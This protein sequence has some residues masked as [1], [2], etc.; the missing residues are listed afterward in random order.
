MRQIELP[1]SSQD[2]HV[3]AA[4][5]AQHRAMHN[6]KRNP[7][8][9]PLYALQ[10]QAMSIGIITQTQQEKPEGKVARPLHAKLFAQCKQ[11]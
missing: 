7:P 9:L 2:V 8:L 11:T 10:H 6:T 1:T 5:S 4:L 3:A